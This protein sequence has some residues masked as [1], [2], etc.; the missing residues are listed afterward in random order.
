MIFSY[1]EFLI[2][3]R[4]LKSKSKES[5]ISVISAFSFLGVA[6][7][8]AAL[9]IVLA[10][11]NGFHIELVDKILGTTGHIVVQPFNKRISNYEELKDK[12]LEVDFVESAYP[13]LES[14]VMVSNDNR[15]FGAIL[16]GITLDDLNDKEMVSQNIVFGNLDDFDEANS[17]VL[18]A[19]L[20]AKLGVTVGSKIMIISP[21]AS[22]TVIGLIPRH[23][24][25]NVVA[26]FKAGIYQYDATSIFL[27]LE[28]ASKYLS[29]GNSIDKIELYVNDPQNARKLSRKIM[30][31]VEGKY[32]VNDWQTA[33]L[34]FFNALEI[35]RTVMFTILALIILVAAFNII[36]SLIM[37]VKDKTHEIAILRT[38][39][40]KR[41]MILR[42]FF[43]CGASIGFFGTLFGVVLG[44]T[45]ALNIDKIK[46]LL[47]SITGATLFDPVIYYLSNLP[48]HVEFSD[49]SRVVLLSLGLCFLATIYPAIRASKLEPVE[50]LRYE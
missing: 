31:I 32:R 5:F 8:V 26:L 45:F 19:E 28:A 40:A 10:V 12:L 49:I 44:V 36:S 24:I 41:S 30:Q 7:G 16:K 3:K 46:N 6:I 43:L 48:A 18:G 1:T 33:D 50:A 35:E 17:V 13:L 14:Q 15:N 2:A 37:L 23:K 47:E 4:I 21:Q 38:I 27:N 20:A 11:M 22:P 39:G 42:I 25:Y 34:S 29:A 9:I